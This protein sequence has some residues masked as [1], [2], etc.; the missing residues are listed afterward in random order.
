[1]YTNKINKINK[2]NCLLSTQFNEIL[3]PPAPN[4]CLPKLAHLGPWLTHLGPWLT[5]SWSKP[6]AKILR[7]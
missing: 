6:C 2:I 7:I 4:V 1:M 5:W 3:I